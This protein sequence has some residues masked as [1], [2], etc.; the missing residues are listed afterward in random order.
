MALSQITQA[1]L[2]GKGV[3]GQ[4]DVPG[5]SAADMQAKVEEIVRDVVIPKFNTNAGNT[6]DKTEVT[7]Q[8]NSKIQEIG[9][10]DMSKAVYDPAGG[11]RQVAFANDVLDKVAYKGT[12]DGTVKSADK[13]KTARSIGGAAFDGTADIT[14][15]Q[16]GIDLADTSYT[17]TPAANV[18]PTYTPTIKKNAIKG[19]RYSIT[20][21]LAKSI[22]AGLN[23][24]GTVNEALN[25][26]TYITIP[27]YVS[28][29]GAVDRMGMLMFSASKSVF[30]LSDTAFSYTAGATYPINVYACNQ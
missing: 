24:V 16:M 5:L 30:L 3:S 15:A 13:L 21:Q 6:Y 10:G 7:A 12:A 1:E 19:I 25:A 23:L 9:A 22:T 4:A 20:L 14:L 27:C 2:T 18:A 8:I 29:Q 17:F 11:V 26:G 28:Q